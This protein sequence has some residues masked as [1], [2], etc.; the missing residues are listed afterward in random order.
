MA[1]DVPTD[2]EDDDCGG[3][4]AHFLVGSLFHSGSLV[5]EIAISF[6]QAQDTRHCDE[7]KVRFCV[8]LKRFDLQRTLQVGE[9]LPGKPARA[10]TRLRRRVR[11][12]L[13]K[14]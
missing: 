9:A 8:L 11:S 1:S 4:D 5:N 10:S 12:D 3:K 14:V 13:T 7:S 2:L 6:Q